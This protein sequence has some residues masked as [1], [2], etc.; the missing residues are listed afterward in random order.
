MLTAVAILSSERND[1]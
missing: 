1:S